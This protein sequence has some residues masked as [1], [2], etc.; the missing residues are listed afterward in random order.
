MPRTAALAAAILRPF[1]RHRVFSTS[2]PSAST[3]KVNVELHRPVGIDGEGEYSA[4]TKGCFDV[5]AAATPA[6]LHSVA[7]MR[8]FPAAG[9]RAFAIADYG[10]ADAGT[11][12]GLI[13]EIVD[14]V[15]VRARGEGDDFKRAKS[16]PRM[17]FQ[18]HYE[19]QRENEW[20]SVFNHALGHSP[21]TNAYGKVQLPAYQPDNGVFVS[22]S[23]IGFHN[24]AYPSSSI[25]LGLSFTAMHWLSKA[26]NSLAGRRPMHVARLGDGN[27]SSA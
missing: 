4:A 3:T 26:P 8:S 20:R 12:L 27:V 16:M 21:V 6:I 13:S 23:G 22:A 7:H 5:I 2:P 15:R 24:Q 17:E 14:A 11:S 10:T 9:A 18:I 1:G 19:D 25:D